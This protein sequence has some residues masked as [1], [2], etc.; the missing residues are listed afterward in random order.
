L[1]AIYTGEPD[2][3]SIYDQVR[4]KVDEIYQ[5]E[6]LR[7]I[8]GLRM[9]RGPL[10][11][12]VL[13][14]S[15]VLAAER[16]NFVNQEVAED[17]LADRLI[18]EF[19]DMTG[20]LIRNAAIAGIAGIR[21][22]A[23]RI[24]AEFDP[25]RDPAYLGHRLLL[26]HPPDA[27]D[28]LEEALASEVASVLEEHRSGTR[29]DIGAIRSWLIHRQSDGLNLSEPFPF[30]GDR[31][32][33]EGWIPL[34]EQGIAAE[35]A[36]PKGASKTSLPTQST[37]PFAEDTE[38]A[39]QSDLHFAALLKLKTHYPSQ[40]PRLSI[41]TILH[42]RENDQDSYFLCLQPK[43]D[44]VRLGDWTGFPFLLLVSL[45]ASKDVSREMSFLAV[46]SEQDVWKHLGIIPKPS[47][48]MI[49]Y[50]QPRDSPPGEVCAKNENALF[51]FEDIEK[52]QYRWIA[53]MKDEHALG[54]ANQVAA[55]LA[56]PGPNEAE[57]LRRGVIKSSS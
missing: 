26:D 25:N 4:D 49:R 57:W 45:T 43:C 56:R 21:D 31:D 27:E 2:L 8:D 34:L 16:S 37:I 55:F 39:R 35:V 28:H 23:H 1:I 33:V 51:F 50:F 5:D 38:S 11:V 29:A 30:E 54:V 13:A 42:T 44:S 53:Q 7:E 46:Q 36:R 24:L 20:G 6:E 22:N 41:G 10:H 15:G 32:P 14:K 52:R 47:K 18:N 19:A 48:L 12:V 17:E 40:A 3:R 9:S